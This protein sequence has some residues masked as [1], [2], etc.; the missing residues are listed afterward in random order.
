MNDNLLCKKYSNLSFPELCDELYISASKGCLEEVKYLLTSSD[1]TMKPF[2]YYGNDSI[3]TVASSNGHIPVVEY[4]LNFNDY[5]I[6]VLVDYSLIKSFLHNQLDL[7][8][9]LLDSDSIPYKPNIHA[10]E[11]YIFRE[12]I[13]AKNKE[14]LTYLIFD[15]EIDKTKSIN[16]Y[17]NQNHYNLNDFVSEVKGW[18][19][20]REL[21]RQL[22]RDLIFNDIQNKK[23]KL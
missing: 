17:L 13:I 16:E 4:L 6:P 12:L 19:D 23:I 8:K 11:D 7:A 20:T 1:L 10:K 5:G 15:M 14:I 9:F 22:N 21:K 18:F 2:I 3:L